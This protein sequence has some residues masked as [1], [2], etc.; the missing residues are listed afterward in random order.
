MAQKDGLVIIPRK[1]YEFL[2]TLKAIKEFSP[3]SSQKKALFL[4][5]KHLKSNK[6]LS[7]DDL[8]HKLGFAS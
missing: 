7:Y 3:T 4:A 6:T 1:E 2:K 5:E 8:V